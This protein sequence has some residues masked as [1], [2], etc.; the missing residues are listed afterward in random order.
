LPYAHSA[1]RPQTAGGDGNSGSNASSP[2]SAQ[3]V[4]PQL[5]YVVL[6]GLDLLLTKG[7]TGFQRDYGTFFHVIT[8]LSMALDTDE[9]IWPEPFQYSPRKT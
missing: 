1:P 2:S 4:P 6:R 9:L 7:S 8:S 5:S 3:A